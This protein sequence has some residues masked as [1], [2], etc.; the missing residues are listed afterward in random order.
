MNFFSNKAHVYTTVKTCEALAMQDGARIIL[1]STDNSLTEVAAKKDFFK[2][3]NVRREFEIVSLRSF[4]NAMK[5]SDMRL[6]NW[7]ETVL[8]N[9]SV[10]SYVISQRDTFDVLYFRDTSLFVPILTA[11]YILR[12]P[13]FIE[14]HAVLHKRYKQ[15]FNNLFA[16]I[17]DGL[18]AISWGLREY[19]EKMNSR[20]VVAFCAAAEPERFTLIHENKERLR[21]DLHLPQ[22]KII[23][24]YSGNLYKTGNYDS[25][26]IE[27]IIKAIPLLDDLFIFVGVGKKGDETKEHEMLAAE[28]GVAE[29][30]IF[31][32]WTT[33]QE[34]YRYWLA[35]D[36]L[37]MPAAGAQIGN[38]PTKMFE[39]LAAGRPIVS[40]DT[41]AIAEVLRDQENALLV[42]YKN[43][44]SWAEAIK[45]IIDYPELGAR[46]VARAL[47][48][49]REYTWQKRGATIWGFISSVI[50]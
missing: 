37:L 1:L 46:L 2:K 27:D 20:I 8:A 42:E 44:G 7:L 16:N 12:K 49:S 38:S 11:K 36:I 17:S 19:Y 25:Y 32:P 15:A 31:L 41:Q 21:E 24:M 13:I 18:I 9:M 28:L 47:L 30:V 3:H 34:I 4:A 14:L 5:G 33:K 35:A 10:L 22:D 23:L 50:P 29:R 48:D 26:G 45:S 43:P 39:Y 40:A 6:M